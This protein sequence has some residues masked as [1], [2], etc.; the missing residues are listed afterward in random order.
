MKSDRNYRERIL[1]Q[2]ETG[3]SEC[4]CTVHRAPCT[5]NFASYQS[6]CA[7]TLAKRAGSTAVG[8]SQA[9][10]NVLL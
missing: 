6:I 2:G 1:H 4:T 5:L 7:L 10:P 3:R 9:V 8:R